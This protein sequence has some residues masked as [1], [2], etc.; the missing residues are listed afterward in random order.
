VTIERS[1]TEVGGQLEW[2]DGKSSKRRT[3]PMPRFVA[4]E[5]AV[6]VAGKKA[7]GLLFTGERSGGVL[8]IRIAR[9]SWFDRAVVESGCPKGLHPHELRHTAASLAEVR[10][11]A[12]DASFD[13]ISDRDLVGDLAFRRFAAAGRMLGRHAA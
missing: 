10:G 12:S 9:R 3:V 11:I 7:D 5:L 8:R 4:S 6:A 1:V 2:T 13:R